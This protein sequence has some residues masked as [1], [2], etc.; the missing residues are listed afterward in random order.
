MCEAEQDPGGVPVGRA[1]PRPGHGSIIRGDILTPCAK[2]EEDVWAHPDTA[3]SVQRFVAVIVPE[4]ST[5][6][7]HRKYEVVR[8]P[9]ALIADP[10]GNEIIRAVG[11]VE[12]PTFLRILEAIPRD[13][14]RARPAAEALA[15]DPDDAKARFAL[16]GFYESTGLREIAEKYYEKALLKPAAREPRLRRDI[17]LARGLNLLKLKQPGPAGRL[18]EEELAAWSDAPDNDVVLLGMVLARLQEG[19]SKEARA[20]VEDMKKRF[21]QSPYTQRAQQAVDR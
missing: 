19:R 18:F 7:V 3:R 16:A 8:M 1:D 2:M 15:R 20:T 13:F 12:R 21:P 14:T 11:Y 6:V 10:W 4:I 9:T 5:R 17:T